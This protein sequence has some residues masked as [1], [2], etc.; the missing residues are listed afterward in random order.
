M[1]ILKPCPFCGTPDGP[2]GPSVFTESGKSFV[3]CIKCGARGPATDAS[4]YTRDKYIVGLWNSR[5]VSPS[6]SEGER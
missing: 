1:A 4:D 6:S 5:S 2:H 3:G